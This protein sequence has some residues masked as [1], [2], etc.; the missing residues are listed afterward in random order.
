MGTLGLR[1]RR[2]S[3]FVGFLA[4]L[5]VGYLVAKVIQKAVG[6]ILDRVS[7]DKLVEM[8]Q[9]FEERKEQA[10]GITGAEQ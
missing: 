3:K 10:Q 1:R 4:I 8:Q 7:F 2:F 5:V 6:R 9:R